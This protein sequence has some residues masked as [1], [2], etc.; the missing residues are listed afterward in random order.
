ML[1]NRQ[2][3]ALFREVEAG[4]PVAIVGAVDVDN[5]V[6]VVLAQLDQG[7]DDTDVD[8]ADPDDAQ[9]ATDETDVE[10]S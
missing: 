2:M 5:T 3:D 10:Q 8:G 9:T 6:A 7:D 4:T 1:G